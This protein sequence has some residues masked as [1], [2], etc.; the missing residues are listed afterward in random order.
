MTHLPFLGL[1]EQAVS[2][3]QAKIESSL[4]IEQVTP[5]TCRQTLEGTIEIKIIGLGH[6][7]EKI[8]VEN[9]KNVYKGVPKIVERWSTTS[10][11]YRSSFWREFLDCQGSRPAD[12]LQ[13]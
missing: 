5:Q 2:L 1:F 4:I 12:Q 3:P 8:V 13:T 6:V 11:K 7:A 9:L 10:P